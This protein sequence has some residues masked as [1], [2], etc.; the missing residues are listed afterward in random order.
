MMMKKIMISL[1]LLIMFNTAS[2]AQVKTFKTVVEDE[3]MAVNASDCVDRLQKSYLLWVRYDYKDKKACKKEAKRD[4]VTGKP[5][6][7]EVLYE[8]D[9]PLLTY[10][11]ISKKYYDK[12]DIVLKEKLIY[13]A[14]WN[15]VGDFDYSLKL[16]I[17]MTGAFH[18]VAG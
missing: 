6:R 5:V 13:N 12:N 8:F 7:L 11:I 17:Y 10:R 18:I 2:F 15:Q 1:L 14:P 16:G 9:E 4:G 3:T